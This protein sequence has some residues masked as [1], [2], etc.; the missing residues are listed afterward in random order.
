MKDK[1]GNIKL[2][3]PFTGSVGDFSFNV[4]S[5]IDIITRKIVMLQARHY[6]LKTFVPYANVLSVAM[7][8]KDRVLKV[9]FEDL[10]FQPG[11]VTLAKNEQTYAKQFI[12]LMKDK[13]KVQVKICG[14]ATVDDLLLSVGTSKPTTLTPEQTE[15]LRSL[16]QQRGDNFKA[17]AVNEGQIKSARLLVCNP[18]V[19]LKAE[20]KPKIQLSF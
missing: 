4:N 14:V 11:V 5:I 8:A 20:A 12:A 10:V 2:D 17:Y 18:E 16:A 6:I 9:H 7:S 3:V 19:D 15:K 1:Q 13:P